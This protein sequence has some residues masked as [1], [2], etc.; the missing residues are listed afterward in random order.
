MVLQGFNTLEHTTEEFVEF[1]EQL[2]FSKDFYVC[3][4]PGQKATTKTGA[5]NT[6]SK[7]SAAK[8]SSKR[9]YAYYCLYHGDNNTHNTNECKVLKAQAEKLAQAH[10]NVGADKYA[11]SSEKSSSE[12][13]KQMQSF[14]AEIVKE[15]VDYFQ[16]GGLTNKKR[17]VVNMEEFII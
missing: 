9:K 1:C 13:K 15:I 12:K 14:K 11:K 3:P 6:D 10:K 2:E 7:Q 5:R 17:R 8:T 16:E 4:N